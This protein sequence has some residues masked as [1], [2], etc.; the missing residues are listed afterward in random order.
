MVRDRRNCYFS[1]W[2]IFCPFTP[3]TVWKMKISKK[4]KN[5][6]E[7]LSFYT[8]I[9]KII[10]LCYTAP[11][12]WHMTHVT[13]IFHFGL[14]FALKAQKMKFLKKWKNTWRYCHFT[15]VYQKLWLDDVRFL[16]YGARQADVQTEGEKKWQIEVRAAPKNIRLINTQRST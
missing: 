5:L 4:F 15:Q 6:L 14:F 11:E 2:A 3:L 16:R 12:I 10:I 13:F 9:Q 8:S 1:F 7:I